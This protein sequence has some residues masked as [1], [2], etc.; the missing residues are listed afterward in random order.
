MLFTNLHYILPRNNHYTFKNPLY[1][2]ILITYVTQ[3]MRLLDLHKV[4]KNK[5]IKNSN[6]TNFFF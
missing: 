2:Y 3:L 5:I 4:T 6:F 1:G